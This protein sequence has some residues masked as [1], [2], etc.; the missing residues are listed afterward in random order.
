[1]G[2]TIQKQPFK[3]R[4]ASFFLLRLF[5]TRYQLIKLQLNEKNCKKC[6]ACHK[7]CPVDIKFN[8]TPNNCECVNRIK[9]MTEACQHQA[10]SC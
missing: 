7:V 4:K 10:T 9:C 3:L 6:T 1:M 2:T 5:F 8:E